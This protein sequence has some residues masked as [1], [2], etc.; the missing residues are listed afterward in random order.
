MIMELVI[1]SI[2]NNQEKIVWSFI[3]ISIVTLVLFVV[4]E[5]TF[6]PTAGRDYIWIPIYALCLAL[7]GF[8]LEISRLN[9]ELSK[10]SGVIGGR[11]DLEGGTSNSK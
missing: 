10:S 1:R 6:I 5:Y 3:T 11:K 2:R 9:W 4:V 8:V 7:I